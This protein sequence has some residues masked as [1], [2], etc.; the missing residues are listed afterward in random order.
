MTK[1]TLPREKLRVTRQE[2]IGQTKEGRDI[3]KVF[4][5]HEDGS[6]DGRELRAFT[7]LPIGEVR[8]YG[9][10]FYHHERY[11]DTWTLLPAQERLVGRVIK[12]EE[13]VKTLEG[14]I[15][16]IAAALGDKAPGGTDGPNR[17]EAT[18]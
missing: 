15:N 18:F 2:K 9:L 11:G 8:E 13:Q 16:Q 7:E 3:Y 10:S 14:R 5:V 4:A 6:A 17:D 1:D 12:L